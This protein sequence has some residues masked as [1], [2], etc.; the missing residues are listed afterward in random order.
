MTDNYIDIERKLISKAL[1]TNSV[2]RLVSE[3]IET[4]HFSDKSS[5]K[6]WK[7]VI[8]H[9][10][11]YKQQPSMT[12]VVD[13]FD[14]FCFDQT[15]DSLDY[16]KDCFIENVKFKVANEHIRMLA[17]VVAAKD[18]SDRL[19]E[20]FLEAAFKMQQSVPSGNVAKF[21]NMEKRIKKYDY[22]KKVGNL[23]GLTTGMKTFDENLYGIKD[24][25]FVVV[26]GFQGTG[27]STLAQYMVFKQYVENNATPLM[28]SL[29]MEEK[30]LYEKWDVM[31]THI[32]YSNLSGLSLLDKEREEW[33]MAAERA[34]NASNDIIVIDNIGKCTVEKVYS[35]ATKYNPD[36]ICVDYMSLMATPANAGSSTWEKL[37]YS[38]R[39]LKMIARDLKIPVIGIAQTNRESSR[40]GA[41]LDNIS[42]GSSIGQDA[43]IIFGLFQDDDM[44]RSKKMEVRMLKNR[45]GP[46][47]NVDMF[48]D[49]N[50]MV[51]E[52]WEDHKHNFY[53]EGL[54]SMS[55][56]NV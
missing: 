24:H 47:A 19:D 56:F 7:M 25:E 50:N 37:M 49:M 3:G 15:S 34:K 38:T 32:S 52:E 33:E 2:E 16:L 27:K 48:W 40:E 1:F 6:V 12:T 14:D 9:I 36:I 18:N 46:T 17:E 13:Q 26:A 11:K 10:L 4:S 43:D 41:T 29:E 44:R 30:S 20:L 39:G 31:A 54:Q 28:I 53:N 23:M 21:S 45:R 35:A 42:Y 5:Q 55:R 22:D 8:D 51:F